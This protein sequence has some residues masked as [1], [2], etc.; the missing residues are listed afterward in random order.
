MADID[1]TSRPKPAVVLLNDLLFDKQYFHSA[2]LR[3]LRVNDEPVVNL[4][5]TLFKH[6]GMQ[7]FGIYNRDP[8]DTVKQFSDLKMATQ[9]DPIPDELQAKLLEQKLQEVGMMRAAIAAKRD[10]EKKD[11]SKSLP[12]G[13]ASEAAAP[14]K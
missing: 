1:P 14:T 5:V 7:D 4:V 11:P 6:G 9:G 3:V 8:A 13:R 12:P 2:T 10:A